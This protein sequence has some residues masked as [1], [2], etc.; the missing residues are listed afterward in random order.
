MHACDSRGVR[1]AQLPLAGVRARVRACL[2]FF[3][4]GAVG[5]VWLIEKSD[6]ISP[7]ISSSKTKVAR[8]PFNSVSVDSGFFRG[9]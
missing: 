5:S 9:M 7:S 2:A 4:R 8:K 1:A 6:A 3:R